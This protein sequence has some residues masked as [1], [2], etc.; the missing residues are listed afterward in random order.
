M[1]LLAEMLKAN[2]IECNKYS[3]GN[4]T[5]PPMHWVMTEASLTEITKD[6]G[7]TDIGRFLQTDSDGYFILAGHPIRIDDTLEGGWKLEISM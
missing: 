2:A 6:A 5:P 1:R 3:T 7:E 4:L